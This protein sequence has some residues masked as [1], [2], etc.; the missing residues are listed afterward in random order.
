MSGLT[1]VASCARGIDLPLDPEAV[2][3][4]AGFG[5]T[6]IASM[7]ATGGVAGSPGGSGGAGTSSGGAGAGPVGAGAS[8]GAAGTGT[9]GAAGS[10]TG[11]AGGAGGD[12]GASGSSGAAGQG[13]S[14]MDASVVD[15][16]DASAPKDA[17]PEM[18]PCP[19][20]GT[21]LS[22]DGSKSQY[23]L[24]PGAALP[25][26]AAP[27]T[28]EIW[29][30]NKSPI[31]NWAPDHTVWEQ[32]GGG[33]LAT[34]AMDFDN[35]ASPRQMELYVNPAANSFFFDTGMMQDR[36]FHL[37]ASFD[38]TKTHAFVNGV[39]IGTGLTIT[40]TLATAANQPLYVGSAKLRNYF[41]GSVD[42]VRIWN[43]ARTQADIARDMGFRLVGN[44]PG[45]V[46]YYRFD[47]GSGTT[48]RDATSGGNNG[49]LTSGPT[50]AAS[51]V[52][53]KCR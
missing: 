2:G 14:A 37:A 9:S 36:W 31:A 11:G 24:I 33:S 12:A 44:E 8:G 25:S 48:A 21:A 5:G 38:G 47:E 46:G 40:G 27:R 50:Y 28:I 53:L 26:G 35:V 34:F 45:L 18:A 41:T 19:G 16:L 17:P 51:G 20:A 49:T 1:L 42:E 23:V 10:S 29:V 15:V 4:S 30:L 52:T 6:F 22:F 7:V 13:G 3:G 39:E 32:A 43:I